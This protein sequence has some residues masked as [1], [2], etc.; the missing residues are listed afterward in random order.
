L[1]AG[2]VVERPSQPGGLKADKGRWISPLPP[3]RR[4]LGRFP[5]S[6]ARWLRCEIIGL[7]GSCGC[8]AGVKGVRYVIEVL[9]VYSRS[10]PQ[11]Q[12]SC[13]REEESST[14]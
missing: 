14:T 4:R 12:L 2:S 11:G 7:L 5:G 10:C 1:E 3:Y 8:G 6:R 9:P 13:N